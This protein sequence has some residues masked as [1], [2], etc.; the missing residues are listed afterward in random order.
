MIK[1]PK[2]KVGKPIVSILSR[3]YK[4]RYPEIRTIQPR[5]TTAFHLQA[6]PAPNIT[7][8]ESTSPRLARA[9]TLHLTAAVNANTPSITNEKY[10]ESSRAALAIT[11]RKLLNKVRVAANSARPKSPRSK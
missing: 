6:M 5:K 11:K 3:S 10:K 7:P 4:K 8:A 9:E 2:S 1:R